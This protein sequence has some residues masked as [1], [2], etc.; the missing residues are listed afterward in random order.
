MPI[1]IFQSEYFL[2]LLSF[3]A[4]F[5]FA[6]NYFLIH[7]NKLTSNPLLRRYFHIPAKKSETGAVLLG[8]LPY[9]IVVIFSTVFLVYSGNFKF[10]LS[11]YEDKLISV[12]AL[13]SLI[14]LIYG[15]LDDKYELRPMV[16]L[17][18]QFI[19]VLAFSLLVS[20]VLSYQRPHLV[21][22]G[23]FFFGMGSVNGCNLIDGLDTLILKVSI[24]SFISYFLVGMFYK[25]GILTGLSA[26]CIIPLCVYYLFNKEPAKIHLGEIGGTF[27]GFTLVLLAAVA[28]KVGR[29]TYAPINATFA[30]AIPLNFAMVEVGISFLRRLYMKKTPFKGDRLHL[31][32]IL[33]IHRKIS[34]SNAAS[35]ISIVNIIAIAVSSY[36]GVNS[37]W[38]LAYAVHT[39]MLYGFQ[40]HIGK[41][42]WKVENHIS[43]KPK[44]ILNY[45]RKKD[46]DK[47]ETLHLPDFKTK[48]EKNESREKESDIKKAS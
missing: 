24:P 11:N 34:P 29:P 15:Y 36:V 25:S 4:L 19:A 46:D 2:F 45:L 14:F 16:K 37:S 17:A 47:L 3:A 30:A 9:A 42:Y 22:I 27:I 1:H 12:W 7:L 20:R 48:P 32:H 28:Y 43:F 41:N 31:H 35:L 26:I 40:W 18:A 33:L 8:G 44:M 23:L 5:S 21:F 13:S 10:F 38:F 39:I 6:G